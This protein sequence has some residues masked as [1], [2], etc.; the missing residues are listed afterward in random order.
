M[1]PAH[2]DSLA[3]AVTALVDDLRAVRVLAEH[4]ALRLRGRDSER[5]S[6][7]ERGQGREGDDDFHDVVLF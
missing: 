3:W 7:G 5:E 6:K 2:E 1:R 4:R